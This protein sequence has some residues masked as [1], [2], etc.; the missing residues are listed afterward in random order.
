MAKSKRKTSKI[1]LILA[2]FFAFPFIVGATLI[3]YN[4]VYMSTAQSTEAVIISVQKE[5]LVSGG[6]RRR[7][8]LVFGVRYYV[9]GVAYSDTWTDK[10]QNA[11]KTNVGDTFPVYYQPGKPHKATT[12]FNLVNAGKIF[13]VWGFI[14]PV[15]VLVLGLLGVRKK[16]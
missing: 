13:I 4:H 10:V 15:F 1:M 16:K 6:R 7:P 2:V 14:Q 12:G 9:D 8:Q 3:I 5:W 11:A